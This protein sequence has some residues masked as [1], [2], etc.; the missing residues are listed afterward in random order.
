[1]NPTLTALIA[2]AVLALPAVILRADDAKA[3]WEKKCALCHGKD[4]SGNA[5]MKTSDYTKAEVQAKMT[6]DDILKAIQSGVSNSKMKGYAGKLSA[7]EIKALA[8]YVR[9]LKK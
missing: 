2:A 7:D 5:K 9:S 4:G 6:D 8:A 1:M 3:L